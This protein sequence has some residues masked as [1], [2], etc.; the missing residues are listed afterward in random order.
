MW[1]W[2]EAISA[3]RADLGSFGISRGAIAGFFGGWTDRII[4]RIVE[5]PRLKDARRLYAQMGGVSA[6][7]LLAKL[8]AKQPSLPALAQ[9]WGVEAATLQ[10]WLRASP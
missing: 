1:L 3:V 2:F 5:R 6:V 8:L 4:S 9:R 10:R 7:D